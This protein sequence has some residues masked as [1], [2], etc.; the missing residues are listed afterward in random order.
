MK[1]IC[2]IS[3]PLNSAALPA[4]CQSAAVTEA[5]QVLPLLT[6]QILTVYLR[7]NKWNLGSVVLTCIDPDQ[8]GFALPLLPCTTDGPCNLS[9]AGRNVGT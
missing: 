9:L 8:Q 2:L 5:R 7:S 3:L 1:P 4:E 6:L